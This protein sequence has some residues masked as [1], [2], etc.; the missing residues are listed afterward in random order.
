MGKGTQ[1]SEMGRLRK[2]PS[3]D[4]AGERLTKTEEMQRVLVAKTLATP[5]TVA[6]YEIF[7]A[8]TL[9]WVTISSSR[10]SSPPRDQKR[11]SC[12]A[13]KLYH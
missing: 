8:R 10:G 7:Q 6:Q 5:G 11:V 3:W 12:I 4:G 2:A 13:G 9:E 1:K